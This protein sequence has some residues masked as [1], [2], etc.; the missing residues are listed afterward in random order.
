VFAQHHWPVWGQAQ[1]VGFI[2]E[3]RDM[4][5]Y[6]HDQTLRMMSHGMTPREIADA[7]MMPSPLS[8]RWHTRGYHGAVGA[9][10]QGD[11]QPL[12]AAA[13][14]AIPRP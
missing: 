3:Q 13:T 1:A 6:L 8:R 7:L 4:Y 2:A 11:L 12:P 5:R 10:R 9:Q 14:T